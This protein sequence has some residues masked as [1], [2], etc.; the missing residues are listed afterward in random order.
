M[1]YTAA[2]LSAIALLG[3]THAA[4]AVKRQ[5]L[6]AS[7][8]TQ[9][10]LVDL[11][12]IITYLTK[13]IVETLHPDAETDFTNANNSFVSLKNSIPPPDCPAV[14]DQEQ[15]TTAQGAIDALNT[16]QNDL[17]QLSLDL[18]KTASSQ[19]VIGDDYC[20][21]YSSFVATKSYIYDILGTPENGASNEA[22]GATMNSDGYDP[23]KIDQTYIET[24]IALEALVSAL[25]NVPSGEPASS[26]AKTAYDNA[27]AAI[28]NFSKAAGTAA[29][30]SCPMETTP[31][32]TD[33]Q[34][35]IDDVYNVE[36]NVGS[37]YADTTSNN[38]QKLVAFCNIA[39]YMSAANDYVMAGTTS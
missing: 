10:S 12:N 34:G 19:T 18:Q 17:A 1:Q 11:E 38:G 23:N 21:A 15:I 3:L 2:A 29:P 39:A 20:N 7:G 37:A 25:T 35:A 24:Q 6:P 30:H 31:G 4:P 14:T 22:V 9:Q 13:D 33:S 16:T 27:E 28:A 26:G 8:V 36:R 5:T 32:A